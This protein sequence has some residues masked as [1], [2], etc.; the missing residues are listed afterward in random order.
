MT[1]LIIFS[2]TNT[3]P[4]I[5]S[6]AIRWWVDAKEMKKVFFL[7][8]ILFVFPCLILLHTRTQWSMSCVVLLRC[9]DVKVKDTLWQSSPPTLHSPLHCETTPRIIRYSSREAFNEVAVICQLPKNAFY[10]ANN[11]RPTQ[12]KQKSS[13]PFQIYFWG[14][15]SKTIHLLH[16]DCSVITSPWIS[17]RGK[18]VPLEEILVFS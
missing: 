14:F 4:V 1:I 12:Q 17:F 18:G 13:V 15:I 2:G 9:V 11:I 8:Q 6:I 16:K 5:S 10:F 3:I 7:Y